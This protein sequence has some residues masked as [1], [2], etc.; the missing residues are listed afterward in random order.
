MC[1]I[2]CFF[3]GVVQA[4]I[5]EEMIEDAFQNEEEEEE[6]DEELEKVFFEVTQQ[7]LG[8]LRV[9]TK[10]AEKAPEVRNPHSSTVYAQSRAAFLHPGP[11]ILSRRLA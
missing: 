2:G 10:V 3:V 8:D 4:G 7:S 1:C 9:G 5:A 6:A 11:L